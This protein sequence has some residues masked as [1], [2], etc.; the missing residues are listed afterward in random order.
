MTF[1]KI[2]L[3]VS[4]VIALA[5]CDKE[6]GLLP[7]PEDRGYHLLFLHSPAERVLAFENEYSTY[8]VD[9]ACA[10]LRVNV[11]CLPREVPGYRTPQPYYAESDK[12]IER[13][14]AEFLDP[15]GEKFNGTMP[16][17]VTY[18]TEVCK[19]IRIS[20]YDKD[21]VFIS[22]ITDGARFY[23]VYTQYE[24]EFDLLINSEKK[25]LGRIAPG[26]TIKEYLSH[27]PMVF[28]DAHFLFPDLD[29]ETFAHG[30]YAK[31]EIELDNGTVL[32]TDS[33]GEEGKD[34]D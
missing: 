31:V 21:G 14:I 29:K 6:D 24:I 1:S 30:N 17:S 34:G 4:A 20:L 10:D 2:L 22:D 9:T 12:E 19:A 3:F 7:P 32:T 26:T 8:T 5:S 33:Y 15:K 27:H 23:Y 18:T 25:L 13:K 16:I 28:A 11:G